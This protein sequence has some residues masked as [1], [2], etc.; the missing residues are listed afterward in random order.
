MYYYFIIQPKE[1][2]KDAFKKLNMNKKRILSY[3]S[4]ISITKKISFDNKDYSKIYN[5]I[6]IYK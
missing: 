2:V 4:K 1:S 5:S 6:F 3:S